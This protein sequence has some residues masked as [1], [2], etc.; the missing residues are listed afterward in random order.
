M[1]RRGQ[2]TELAWRFRS[3]LC[4]PPVEGGGCPRDLGIGVATVYVRQ[5]QCLLQMP[6]PKMVPVPSDSGLG[7]LQ[8]SGEEMKT[9]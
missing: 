5:A 4:C 3:Q 7:H 1:E 9:L 8:L 2:N 6:G